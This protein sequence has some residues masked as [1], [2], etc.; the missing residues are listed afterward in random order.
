MRALQSFERP[1]WLPT[2]V[3]ERSEATSSK[4]GGVPWLGRDEQWPRCGQCDSYMNLFLQLGQERTLEASRP[5]WDQIT[6]RTRPSWSFP[7]LGRPEDLTVGYSLRRD[8]LSVDE[9]RPKARST[10]CIENLL[11]VSVARVVIYDARVP[12]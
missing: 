12:D 8:R 9:L 7:R 6:W 1:A 10:N 2:L 3:E 5:R 4:F 11:R